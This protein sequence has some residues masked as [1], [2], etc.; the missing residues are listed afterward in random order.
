LKNSKYINN[1][2]FWEEN[3]YKDVNNGIKFFETY[4]NPDHYDGNSMSR[5]CELNSVE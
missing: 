1:K 3:C 2:S 4:S 5:V